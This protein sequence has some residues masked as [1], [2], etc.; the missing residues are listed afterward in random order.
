MLQQIKAPQFYTDLGLQ[1][2][3]NPPVNGTIQEL[4]KAFTCFSSPF[5][6]KFE[7]RTFQDSPV[8]LSTFQ[9]C[10]NPVHVSFLYGS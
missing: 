4:F 6:G 7:L 10:A 8:Y 3:L 2:V 9:A 1:K 5:Q